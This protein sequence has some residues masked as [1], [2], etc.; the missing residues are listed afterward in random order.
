VEHALHFDG[1]PNE[2]IVL[3]HA[4]PVTRKT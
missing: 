3:A 1:T 4:L 2:P